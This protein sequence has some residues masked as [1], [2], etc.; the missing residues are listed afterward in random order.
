MVTTTSTIRKPGKAK[1]IVADMALT[2]LIRDKTSEVSFDQH[3]RVM[4]KNNIHVFKNPEIKLGDN[5]GCP[6]GPPPGTNA[7]TNSGC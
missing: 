3:G 6:G 4:F 5:L 7:C 2:D 1:A